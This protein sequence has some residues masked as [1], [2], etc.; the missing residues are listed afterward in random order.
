MR[1]GRVHTG[2]TENHGEP[3]SPDG[4]HDEAPQAVFQAEDIEVHQQ[5]HLPP[6]QAQVGQ[7]LRLVEWH[8]TLDAFQLEKDRSTDN[9]VCDIAAIQ[10]CVV[11]QDALTFRAA[12]CSEA[13]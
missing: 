10:P 3:L 4:S 5:P 7:K 13:A 2:I 9:N 11:I 6:A 1:E 12:Q 8:H